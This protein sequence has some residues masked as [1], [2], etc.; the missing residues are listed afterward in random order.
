[1]AVSTTSKLEITFTDYEDKNFTVGYNHAKAD[2]T[3]AQVKN[4]A[5]T[6]LANAEIFQRPMMSKVGAKMI[7][8]TSTDID[9][10]ND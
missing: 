6:M 3:A 5:D 4:L 2:A 1:M 9:I 10:M 7:T 8:T